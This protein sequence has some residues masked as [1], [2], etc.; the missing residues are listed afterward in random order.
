M[1]DFLTKKSCLG[2]N[3]K[4]APNNVENPYFAHG[5]NKIAF[6]ALRLQSLGKN[7]FHTFVY[8]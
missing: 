7:E 6:P 3:V 5:E 1:L 8:Q 4:S 2:K